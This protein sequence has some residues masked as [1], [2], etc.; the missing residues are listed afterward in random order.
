MELTTNT[1]SIP[2]PTDVILG[3]GKKYEK[4]PGNKVFQGMLY[5]GG[6]RSAVTKRNDS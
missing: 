4:N 5:Y 6:K 2:Q 3:R 1:M